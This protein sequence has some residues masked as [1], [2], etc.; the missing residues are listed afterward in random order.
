MYPVVGKCPIC[1]DDLTV[2]RL[3]CRNC[4]SALEGHFNLGRFYL[5][6]A[7]QLHF[8]ETFIKN[9]GK[10]TR[11]EE[12]LGLSYPTVRSRLNDVIRALGYEVPAEAAISTERRQSI[13]ER[14]QAGE[15]T[16][17]EAVELLK[18]SGA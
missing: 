17:G 9:E 1:G 7:E 8:V 16:A 13:L 5:L 10:I 3:H 4:D 11:V 12:E 2:T 14:V 15:I 18:G 6:S